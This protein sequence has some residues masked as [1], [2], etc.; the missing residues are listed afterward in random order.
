MYSL[1]PSLSVW[2]TKEPPPPPSPPPP[3]LPS[4]PPQLPWCCQCMSSMD[5]VMWNEYW[6][7]TNVLRS[8]STQYMNMQGCKG[9]SASLNKKRPITTVLLASSNIKISILSY[10][11]SLHCWNNSS[12]NIVLLS[13]YKQ[14]KEVYDFNKIC[15]E[16][17]IHTLHS[18]SWWFH[19][20]HG[21]TA[22]STNVKYCK[23]AGST[24]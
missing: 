10:I 5:G 2:L 19:K 6:R 12:S 20:M 4:L 18:L 23:M 21:A 11:F 14:N 15:N 16:I 3:S 1:S 13:Q 7:I 22:P 24:I 8:T 17:E 9:K